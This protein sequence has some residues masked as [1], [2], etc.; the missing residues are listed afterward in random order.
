MAYKKLDPEFKAKWVKALRSGRY[1]QG[2][3]RLRTKTGGE[4]RYCC[5]GVAYNIATNGSG[6]TEGSFGTYYTASR[7]GAYLGR[8]DPFTLPDS[9]QGKL[10]GMNDSGSWDFKRIAD[11][12]EK[13]L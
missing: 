8:T 13:N 12:I 1:K 3:S 5:L 7:Q 6:W 9:L 11:W 4:I 10:A 2:T